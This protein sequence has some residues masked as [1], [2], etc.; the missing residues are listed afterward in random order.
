MTAAG[1]RLFGNVHRRQRRGRHYKPNNINMAINIFA[2]GFEG[3]S[4]K[5][6]PMSR[7]LVA[8]LQE[9]YDGGPYPTHYLVAEAFKTHEGAKIPAATLR[10]RLEHTL[11]LG[12]IRCEFVYGMKKRRDIRNYLRR[13][14][15]FVEK[16][17]AA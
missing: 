11:Y 9:A 16:C 17:E 7:Y 4:K 10:Q 13:Y 14:V 2:E 6:Y 1:A 12:E 15:E 5:C 3:A 8:H